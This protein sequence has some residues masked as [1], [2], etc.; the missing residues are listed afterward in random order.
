M[1]HRL[2]VLSPR[3]IQCLGILSNH[4]DFITVQNLADVLKISKRTLFRELKDIDA[5]LNPFGIKLVSK[6]GIG[7][8][9]QG[10]SEALN[11][12]RRQLLDAG[13]SMSNYSK[14]DRQT[15]L[16]AE[17]L[18]NQQLDKFII[19]A[20]QFQVSEAT[21]SHDVNALE[22]TL[23]KY[24][25]KLSRKPGLNFYLLGSEENIRKAIREFI[26]HHA[27]EE[28]FTK[29]LNF[30]SPWDV[31][32]FF[33]AHG[34]NSILNILNKDILRSV[35][36]VL[37]E[38]DFFWVNQL[39]QTAYVGLIIHI[40]IAIERLKN[41]ENIEME[42]NLMKQLQSDP[43]FDKA[44]HLSAYF[45]ENFEVVF[46]DSEI[47]YISMHLKG[48]RRL[49]VQEQQ[50]EDLEFSHELL[51]DYAHRLIYSFEKSLGLK[52]FQ[53]EYLVSGLLT[54]LRPALTRVKYGMEIRNPL[55]DQIKSQYKD[56][57]QVSKTCISSL[58]DPYFNALNEDETGFI[59]MHF[60]AALER[61]K[62]HNQR[63]IKVAVLCAS[64]IGISALLA[65]R[66]KS[67]FK[68]QIEVEARS[69]LLIDQLK[70]D[71]FQMIISTME[72]QSDLP[73]VLVN[74]LLSDQDISA[75]TLT[76]STCL[77]KEAVIPQAKLESAK[78]DLE[79][80]T[81]IA[82]GIHTIVD[83][84]HIEP[85]RNDLSISDMLRLISKQMSSSLSQEEQL[86]KDLKDREAMGNVIL[87]DEGI[88][89]FHA[90]T[91][92]C[93]IAKMVIF[94]ATEDIM[95]YRP[96]AIRTVLVLLVGRHQPM[97]LNRWMSELSA[98]LIEDNE[99]LSLIHTG[100]PST[101]MDYV[102]KRFKKRFI[103]W[104]NS[105]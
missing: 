68:D 20:N 38:N 58:N 53:D 50:Y 103:E 15:I 40:T 9:L 41:H 56:V 101:L 95:C 76:M 63:S 89:L 1:S 81:Q 57:Y 12:F 97:E 99:Y 62:L 80:T 44:K 92:A 22:A 11:L 82:Q 35:I 34:E 21:I 88:V 86:F 29:L 49:N 7:I 74:P 10:Q 4:E 16:L 98:S 6:T 55:L 25:L 73:T 3:T 91:E 52:L 96:N 72:V 31:E 64:G 70:K 43:M 69:H 77:S 93:H 14:E 87:S 61:L 90:R 37:K 2:S 48:A 45:E 105:L 84:I 102:A 46:P 30:Q 32:Q 13:L 104:V 79:L 47:A 24:Q 60:G 33:N 66:L 18:K 83:S 94:R 26:Y 39:A 67:Q 27:Q 54:H 51:L 65:S 59:A 36:H 75:I 100:H 42:Q 71:G 28:R 19:Y 23:E 17:V 8:Q 5:F 85:L 78:K